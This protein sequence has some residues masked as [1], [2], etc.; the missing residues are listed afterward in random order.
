MKTTKNL[1]LTAGICFQMSTM[2][3]ADGWSEAFL[4]F[5]GGIDPV[6]AAQTTLANANRVGAQGALTVA[7]N[8]GT[9]E[10][11][12]IG[13]FVSQGRKDVFKS[14]YSDAD[15]QAAAQDIIQAARRSA[16]AAVA[17][18]V[19]VVQPAPSAPAIPARG[20]A[21]PFFS[22]SSSVQEEPA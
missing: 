3:F 17:E 14:D 18:Q 2:L 7:K 10:A 6:A 9:P 15:V 11:M 5:G 16:Q 22:G 13:R 21:I 12:A 4:A 20:W 8:S 19:R 1:L